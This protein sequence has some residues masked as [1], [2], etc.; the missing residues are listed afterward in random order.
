MRTKEIDGLCINCHL[1]L[2]SE[3]ECHRC[4]DIVDIIDLLIEEQKKRRGREAI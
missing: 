3:S 4:S 1:Y 2:C